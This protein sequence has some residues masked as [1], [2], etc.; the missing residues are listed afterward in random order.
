[1]K[2]TMTTYQPTGGGAVDLYNHHSNYFF[3]GD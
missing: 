3:T 1:M 2:L